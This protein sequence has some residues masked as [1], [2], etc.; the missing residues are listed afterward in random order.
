MPWFPG[1]LPGGSPHTMTGRD[2]RPVNAPAEWQVSA[3]RPT[4]VRLSQQSMTGR[5]TARRQRSGAGVGIGR[6][7]DPAWASTTRPP[8]PIAANPPS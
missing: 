3:P 2:T 8:F 5:D 4:G 7:A 1:T 6:Q